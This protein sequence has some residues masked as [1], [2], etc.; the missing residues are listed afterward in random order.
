[1]E[2]KRKFS[3]YL[4]FLGCFL[5]MVFP[6]G[7]L[8]YTSGLFMYPI[9]TEYGFS[10]TAYS[11]SS[12]VAAG[13]NA[14]TSAFLVGYLS[15]GSKNTMKILML[16]SAVITC[17]GFALMSK[18]TQ[19]WQ[20]I[21]MQG[22]WNLG[23][24]MLCYT[25]VGMMMANWFIKKRALMTGIA[26]AGGN[27]GGAIFNTVISQIMANQGWRAAYVFG[28][29][30]SFVA[31]V[32]ALLLIKRSPAEYGQLA[33]GEG[34]ELSTADGAATQKTWLGVDKKTAMKSPATYLICIAMFCTGI[35]AAGI[36]NHVVTFLCTGTWEITVAG[37]VMTVFTLFGMA[38][39]ALGGGIIGKTGTKKGILAGSAV[40]VIAVLCLMFANTVK[41]LAYVWAALQGLASFMAV[42]IPSLV[43]TEIFGTRDYA[44]I[45]G[46]VYAFYLVGCAVSAPLIAFMAE[47]A[48][49]TVAWI[50]V[51]AVILIMAVLHMKAQTYGKKFR[52]LYPD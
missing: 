22:V 16:V 23:Y 4:V 43:V 15:K 30:I 35:Y 26:F 52:E 11:L 8:S 14:L 32:I 21:V 1:M 50:G 5:L 45:Y 49:Y 9:C 27:L 6:G 18:C 34:E 41:P 3:G 24:N 40:L 20:F 28:G 31:I 37:G 25:P 13:V 36:A 38:G 42:L 29:S 47:S 17:G 12:T 33:L 19:L 39:N 46:F 2:Q 10:L 44:G 48:S 7:L 51:I